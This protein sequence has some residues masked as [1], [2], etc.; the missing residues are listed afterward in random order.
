MIGEF[1]LVASYIFYALGVY[2]AHLRHGFKPEATI[3]ARMKARG[4]IAFVAA[5]WPYLIGYN[6]SKPREWKHD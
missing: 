1:I 5:L 4:R 3:R 2:R 6:L